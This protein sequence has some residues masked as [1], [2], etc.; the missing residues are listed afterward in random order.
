[1]DYTQLSSLSHRHITL[2][3]LLD[4]KQHPCGYKKYHPSKKM[5]L[6]RKDEI[7]KELL[8]DFLLPFI[9]L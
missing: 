2:A 3:H 9:I 6:S 4:F 1:M 5:M 8:L 7:V